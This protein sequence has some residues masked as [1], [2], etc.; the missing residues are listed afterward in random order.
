MRSIPTGPADPAGQEVEAEAPAL[1]FVHRQSDAVPR[2]GAVGRLE[3]QVRVDAQRNPVE[4]GS[5]AQM[6]AR[7]GDLQREI[8]V[9]EVAVHRDIGN[10]GAGEGRFHGVL[11]LVELQVLQQRK[12]EMKVRFGSA[13]DLRRVDPDVVGV[14][15]RL[16]V[17]RLED[18]LDR[19]GKGKVDRQPFHRGAEVGD[20]QRASGSLNRFDRSA[21]RR[22]HE[23]PVVEGGGPADLPRR[24]QSLEIADRRVAIAHRAVRRHDLRRARRRIDR[25]I[26]LD[27]R[28]VENPVMNIGQHPAPP[29]AAQGRRPQAFEFR[30][31]HIGENDPELAGDRRRR[32]LGAGDHCRRHSVDSS[33]NAKRRAAAEI[34]IELGEPQLADLRR[35]DGA[36]RSL[37]QS[38]MNL[39]ATTRS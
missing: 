11:D 17:D 34:E 25:E 30:H 26:E 9:G 16:C 4:T 22:E 37:L 33:V 5:S 8:A 18:I 27:G 32:G 36:D 19:S 14:A 24:G 20:L 21:G 13:G 38:D 15:Q 2:P 39:P 28:L 10:R 1:L 35:I 29:A 3:E 6:G 12:L 7:A 23:P 31:R